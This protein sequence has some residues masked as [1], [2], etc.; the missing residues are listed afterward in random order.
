MDKM[1]EHLSANH[2]NYIVWRYVNSFRPHGDPTL[3]SSGDVIKVW[4]TEPFFRYLQESG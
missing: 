4:L 1:A 3:S 2:V